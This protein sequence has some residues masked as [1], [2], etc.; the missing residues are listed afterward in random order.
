LTVAFLS[1]DIHCSNV[2]EMSFGETAA[3]K[4]LKAFSTTSSAFYWPFPFADGEPSHYV[5]DSTDRGQLDSFSF[6][7]AGK[8]YV[9]NYEACNFTQDDNYC[10]VDVDRLNK[11][12]RVRAFDR[13]GRLIVRKNWLTG[14]ETPLEKELRLAKW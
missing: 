8:K 5:H 14:K 2:A 11:R 13:E 10:R 3:A 6:E 9:M 7:A 4:K 12:L 1:G